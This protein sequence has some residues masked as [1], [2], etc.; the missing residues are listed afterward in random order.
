MIPKDE[1]SFL[2]LR[3]F[4]YCFFYQFLLFIFFKYGI[5]LFIFIVSSFKE[6]VNSDKISNALFPKGIQRYIYCNPI[7]PCIDT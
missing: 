1:D 2:F 7:Q 4:C 5:R 3:K 6:L